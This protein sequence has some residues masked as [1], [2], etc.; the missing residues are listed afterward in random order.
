MAVETFEK[1]GKARH[2]RVY[3]DNIHNINSLSLS[4]RERWM[5][6]RGHYGRGGWYEQVIN[7]GAVIAS[8]SMRVRFI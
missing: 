6:M 7:R 5:R 1:E 3:D 4:L 8:F 2:L